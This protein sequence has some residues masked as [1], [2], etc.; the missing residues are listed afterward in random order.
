MTRRGWSSTE[1]FLAFLDDEGIVEPADAMPDEYR[2]AVFRFIELHANSELMG[3]L[4]ERD[5]R[6]AFTEIDK[7]HD[8]AIAF[9]EFAVWWASG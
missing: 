6:A 3:G 9:D 4:T 2:H 1:D 7:D 8:G 5:C